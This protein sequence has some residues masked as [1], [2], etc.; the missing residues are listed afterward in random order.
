MLAPRLRLDRDAL[1]FGGHGEDAECDTVG[2]GLK[3]T[4]AR[5]TDLRLA[6]GAGYQ[7]AARGPHRPIL[8]VRINDSRRITRVHGS[9]KVLDKGFVAIFG[10]HETYSGCGGVAHYSRHR[11]GLANGAA[12]A[13]PAGSEQAECSGSTPGGI[14]LAAAGSQAGT[15]RSGLRPNSG[16]QPR[17]HA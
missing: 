9:E 7:G 17:R 10:A 14:C 4:P 3:D 5:L 8:G 1:A 16:T 6:E 15:E 11:P 13:F 2:K 12:R